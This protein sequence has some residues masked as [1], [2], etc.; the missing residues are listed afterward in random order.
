MTP[1]II[2]DD[3]TRKRS[4]RRIRMSK[5]WIGA[6]A[7]C[8][9][10]G[11]VSCILNRAWLPMVCGVGMN[12]LLMYAARENIRRIQKNLNANLPVKT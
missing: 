2:I 9:P 1:P 6:L 5:I 8:L 10:I 7:V 11:I 12:L 3:R 4:L